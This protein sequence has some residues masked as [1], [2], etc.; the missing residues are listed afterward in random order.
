LV[1]ALSEAETEAEPFGLAAL[2]ALVSAPGSMVPSG[3]SVSIASQL[4][5]FEVP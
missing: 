3:F 1:A 2:M 5:A 4:L